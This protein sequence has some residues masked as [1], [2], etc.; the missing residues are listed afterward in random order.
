MT[1]AA[2]IH[3]SCWNASRGRLKGCGNLQAPLV[4][5]VIP[6]Y[7]TATDLARCIESVRRQTYQNLEI[8]LVNDGSSDS[9]LPICEMYARVDN[10]MRIIDRP[11]SG[12]SAS[13]NTAI[14]QAKGRF[15]QFVDSDDYL[16]PEATEKLVCRALD[17]Q[18]DLVISHY[19]RVRGENVSVHGFLETDKVLSLEEFA[20]HLMDEPASFYYGVMWN[21]LYRTDL[22]QEHGIHCSEELNWSEDFL[23]NLHYIRY[24]Q[25]FCAL[26]EPI[27]YYVKNKHSLTANQI[28]KPVNVISTKLNLFTYYKDL[29]TRLGLYEEYK[30]QIHKYLIAVAEHG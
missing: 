27:Y 2:E 13:R 28:L 10:R 4:T 19:Y 17:T 3:G 14:D 26:R 9:S 23:F 18:C 29:Y 22:I 20:R 30:L 25:R 15:L 11:N 12:V 21:K 16:I 7:N 6:V 24:S 5:I 8:L 1:K